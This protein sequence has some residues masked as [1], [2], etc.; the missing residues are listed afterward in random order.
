MYDKKIEDKK[1]DKNKIIKD[2]TNEDKNLDELLSVSP[3]D[4]YNCFHNICSIF[5]S[6]FDVVYYIAHDN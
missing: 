3:L 1:K 5:F 6:P 2:L 4:K